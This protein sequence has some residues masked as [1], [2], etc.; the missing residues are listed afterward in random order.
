MSTSVISYAAVDLGASSGRV[1]VGRVGPDTLE[2]TEAHRFPNRPVRVPEGL[3]W[4]V[5]GLYAGVLEGLRAAGQVASVGVDSW[6]VDY[7]L[8][9]AD[10]A[11]LGNPV[12]YR[13]ARTEGVAEKVWA[14]VPAAE[15]Y[16]ATGL[17]YAP[18]NTLY[19][20]TAA[21]ST[22]QLTYAKRLLMIPD[23]LTYW[24]TGEQ[25][26]ELTNASTTQL[27]DPRTRDWAY[28]VA[29]RLGI[30]LGLFPPLR[31][32]G[33]P[34]GVLRP[35]VL[36]ETGLSGP[37]P[38]TAVG[39]HDTASAVA[40]V[41]A[42][43]E[44]FAYICTG[45]WSLA[46]LELTAPVLTE[47]SRAANFT[48]ELG[49]DGT[50][51]YLRNIM[52][53]WLLQE[54]LRAWGETDLGELLRA[55]GEVPEL[56]SVVDAGDAAFLAPGR[57]PERIAEACRASGQPVPVTPAEITR[58]ILD[59]LALAH[60]KAVEDAQRLTGHPVDVVHVVGGGARNALLCQLTAD[61]CGLPVVA[62]PAEAAALGNVLV[63]A[64]AGGPVGDLAG[65]RD[66]LVR[67][68]RPVRYEPRGD[69]ARWRAA[70]AR[71]ADR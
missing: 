10:G 48:N 54:C 61:A 9:D 19:Q 42:T 36:E 57:M 45:T 31:L 41:P 26:T 25:G 71:L 13:D 22:D 50:V 4:D 2:L 46:G 70:E 29:E 28:D 44:R 1:M 52:G 59:S 11:L 43:D 16:A 49:L 47:E 6:A 40:A 66:L 21:R 33:D 68:Q 27:I 51:R 8:L 35:E 30:D 37:V 67:T 15:L 64:R 55:A 69:A 5:L 56:R 24:L 34:A 32:P 23:L 14:S 18:F 12:H 17:Q 60:R 58:C 7:G 53:L 63:Q 38:V 39:S 3:R 20:L 65:M 62:G